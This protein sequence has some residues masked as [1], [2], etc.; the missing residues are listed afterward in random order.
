MKW[1]ALIRSSCL[2]IIFRL[3]WW[4]WCKS[5]CQI[6]TS[7]YNASM[8]LIPWCWVIDFLRW[9]VL[10]IVQTV[11]A[12]TIIWH[13]S[14]IMCTL[15]QVWSLL[16]SKCHSSDDRRPNPTPILR[17]SKTDR[18]LLPLR[19]PI[20]YLPQRISPPLLETWVLVRHWSVCCYMA[21]ARGGHGAERRDAAGA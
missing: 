9:I 4:R 21:F 10:W 8:Q 3:T 15:A 18:I 14:F 5:N 20:Q 13:W 12:A 17:A 16:P 7:W 2:I 6:N 1:H 11:N 19:I